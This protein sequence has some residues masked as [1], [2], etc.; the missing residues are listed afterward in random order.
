MNTTTSAEIRARRRGMTQAEQLA[1][2]SASELAKNIRRGGIAAIEEQVR[3]DNYFRIS[4]GRTD[5]ERE[6][7][8]EAMQ[9]HPDRRI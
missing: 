5:L 3:R 4:G 8:I 1:D 6:C 9:M 2:M 7:M